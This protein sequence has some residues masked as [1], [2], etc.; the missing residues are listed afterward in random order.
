MAWHKKRLR[1]QTRSFRKGSRPRSQI[2]IHDLPSRLAG[3][4]GKTPGASKSIK[5]E[6]TGEQRVN[7]HMDRAET[8][9]I[10]ETSGQ[11]CRKQGI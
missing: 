3:S 5:I 2:V 4:S 1:H 9:S 7:F 6:K 10:L 11:N 8:Q